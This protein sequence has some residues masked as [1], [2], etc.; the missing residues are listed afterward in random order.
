M[1]QQIK[2]S[3]SASKIAIIGAVNILLGYPI[4]QQVI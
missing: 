2:P 3:R 4:V 1:K